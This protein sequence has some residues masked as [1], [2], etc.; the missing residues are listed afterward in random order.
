MEMSLHPSP[1]ST[2]GI[3]YGDQP[4]CVCVCARTQMRCP[5]E[6][7]EMLGAGTTGFG[8]ITANVTP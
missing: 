6:P 5:W 4:D 2:K 7:L 1:E 3:P 8:V